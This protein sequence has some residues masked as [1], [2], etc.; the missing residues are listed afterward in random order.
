L[1][2]SA[3]AAPSSV[4]PEYQFVPSLN[5]RSESES[6]DDLGAET[7]KNAAAKGFGDAPVFSGIR[8]EKDTN[9]RLDRRLDCDS[10]SPE[11]GQNPP[12]AAGAE[13]L[14]MY[15]GPGL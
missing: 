8:V 14:D 5:L 2:L 4:L 1:P 9:L 13:R 3:R 11:R 6:N 12:R 15:I 10:E 7:T